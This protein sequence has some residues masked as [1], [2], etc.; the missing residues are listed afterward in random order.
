[1][2]ILLVMRYA[3]FI[4]HNYLKVDESVIVN[5]PFYTD[6]GTTLGLVKISALMP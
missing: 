1:M 3:I 5:L 4:S 2:R 6:F